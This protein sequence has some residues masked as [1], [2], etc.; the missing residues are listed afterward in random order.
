MDCMQFVFH[1]GRDS[2]V[3]LGAIGYNFHNNLIISKMMRNGKEIENKYV[4]IKG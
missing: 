3:V 1:T 2:I 4:M